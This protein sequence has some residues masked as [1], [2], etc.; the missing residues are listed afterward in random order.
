MLRQSWG[1]E[2]TLA[3]PTCI[4]WKKP[5]YKWT[6]ADQIHAVW[7]STV[8]SAKITL[9]TVKL[10]L[11]QSHQ[12]KTDKGTWFESCSSSKAVVKN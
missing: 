2:N 6:H 3:V 1:R 10:E 9:Y 8:V 11:T 12:C 5:A 4:Y 7:D